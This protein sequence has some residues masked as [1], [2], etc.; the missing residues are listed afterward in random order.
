MK[1]LLSFLLFIILLNTASATDYYVATWGNNSNTGLS[2]D[3]AWESPYYAIVSS[4]KINPGT[5]VYVVDGVYNVT[6]SILFTSDNDGNETHPVTLTAYNGTPIIDGR[7]I[8]TGCIN[9]NSPSYTPFS[10]RYVT[11]SNM[12]FRYCRNIGGSAYSENITWQNVTMYGS[13]VSGSYGLFGIGDGARNITIKDSTFAPPVGYNS[14]TVGS[15]N[16]VTAATKT[17]HIYFTNN[18]VYGN[19]IH[20]GFQWGNIDNVTVS[21]N[22]FWDN[23]GSGGI[24]LYTG[25][26]YE[27][28]KDFIIRDTTFEHVSEPIYISE[29]VNGLVENITINNSGTIILFGHLYSTTPRYTLDNVTF[30]N[31]RISKINYTMA[32]SGLAFYL[33]GNNGGSNLLWEN[34]TLIGNSITSSMWRLQDTKSNITLRDINSTVNYYIVL[35]KTTYASASASAII[36]YSDGKVFKITSVEGTANSSITTPI[37]Y[38]SDKSNYSEGRYGNDIDRRFGVTTYPMT[39]RPSSSF[40]TVTTDGTN[41][42]VNQDISDQPIIDHTITIYSNNSNTQTTFNISTGKPNT[43]IDLNRNGSYYTGVTTNATGWFNYK[44]TGGFSTYEFQIIENASNIGN[45][46][47]YIYSTD[48][49]PIDNA[50]VR[51]SYTNGSYLA[52]VNTSADGSYNFTNVNSTVQYYIFAKWINESSAKSANFSIILNSTVWQNITLIQTESV[53]I[54][55]NVFVDLSG[56]FDFEGDT[57]IYSCN[58]TD[59]FTDFGTI[60]GKGNWTTSGAGNYSVKFGASDDVGFSNK[61]IIFEVTTAALTYNISGFVNDTLGSPIDAVSVVNGTNSTTTNVTGY[62]TIL[63]SNGTY[64]FSYTKAGYVTGYKEITIAGA[65]VVNQ[66]VTLSERVLP[67]GDRTLS[68]INASINTNCEVDQIMYVELQTQITWIYTCS[69]GSSQENASVGIKH[70]EGIWINSTTNIDKVRSW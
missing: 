42:T 9:T 5:T 17:H 60:T 2:L 4:G 38:Y 63:M 53:T 44:Y 57:I 10:V 52:V 49:N 62:Y 47:G 11:I 26:P 19:P 40:A 68:Q 37:R 8:S 29:G 1:T 55:Q 70:G 51:L 39:V 14:I 12:V 66:N 67:S 56:T 43:L 24:D 18:N 6:D 61:T 20:G 30:R 65:D 46:S 69:L 25:H 36:E 23:T 32:N 50:T 27:N 16:N 21:G 31:I 3:Q 41:L 64:N 48:S 7:N 33:T 28:L 22:H 13:N 15:G 54:G 58:R 59:L 45:L 35:L 34:I